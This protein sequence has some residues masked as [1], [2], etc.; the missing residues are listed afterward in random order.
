MANVMLRI[1]GNPLLCDPT[2]GAATSECTFLVI[3]NVTSEG[4]EI[5]LTFSSDPDL[6]ELHE[7]FPSLDIYFRD[8]ALS[9]NVTTNVTKIG[10]S[11]NT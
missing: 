11:S 6:P 1:D 3:N 10:S 8:D 9:S 7:P 5:I 2:S 4:N